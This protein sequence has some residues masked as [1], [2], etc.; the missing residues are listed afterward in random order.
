MTAT[1]GAIMS[2]LGLADEK[3]ISDIIRPIARDCLVALLVGN[4]SDVSRAE[5]TAKLE[6]DEDS[7]ELFDG[8]AEMVA[9][10]SAV[11]AA[12]SMSAE[13]TRLRKEVADLREA[14]MNI[15]PYLKWTISEESPGHHPTMPSA[16]SAF[17]SAFG[18]G[19]DQKWQQARLAALTGD[20]K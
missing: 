20:D 10:M 17:M 16:V 6:A 9:E 3:R 2:D 13:L 5:A 1:S 18:W 12:K 14:A 8:F 7:R 4:V 11:D 15:A 19:T